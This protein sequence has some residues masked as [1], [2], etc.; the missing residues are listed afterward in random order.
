MSDPRADRFVRSHLKTRHLVL[1]VELGRHGSI[2]HAA[3]AANLTQ[4]AASKLLG[5]LEHALGVPLFE[6]L[7]RGVVPTSYGEVLIRRAGAA[8]SEMD[9]AHQEIMELLSG[10][11]GRVAV[12]TVMT[13]SINLLPQTV[14]LLKSRYSRVHVSI[15][16]DSS[17]VLIARLRAGELDMVIGRI[18]DSDSANE[19]HFEP[20]T[21]EPHSLIARAGHPLVN[22][23][24]LSL[25]QLVQEGWIMPPAGSILRDRLTALFLSHGLDQ[26]AETVETTALPMITNLLIG[27]NMI[28]ALPE[29]LVRPYI[30]I[31]LLTVLPYDLGLRM[32]WYGIVTRKQHKLSPGAQ[33]MLTT[34][35][36]VA[37]TLYQT[38]PAPTPAR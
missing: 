27:S 4:P 30:D 23:A 32:D 1:L 20:L 19:L 18:L 35:R 22:Q 12:G 25:E 38:A 29:E 5:E 6:R 8:L 10:L 9:A 36:D 15:T 24:D 37:A 31:G 33:A 34:L 2:L 3:Q 28:S 13:P 11:S 7:P 17:K 26:P 16:V 14:Q 21:D